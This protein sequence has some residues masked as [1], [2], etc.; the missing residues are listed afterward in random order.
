[1]QEQGIESEIHFLDIDNEVCWSQVEKR[2]LEKG[3][4]FVMTVTKDMFEYMKSNFEEPTEQETKLV[5][6]KN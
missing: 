4:T 3:T 1:M 5:T 2:N 6:V